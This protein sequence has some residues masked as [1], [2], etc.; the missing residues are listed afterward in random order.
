MCILHVFYKKNDNKN[1][2]PGNQWTLF[3]MSLKHTE[4][5]KWSPND[6]LLV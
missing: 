3:M 5:N 1:T 4:P 2:R 6:L